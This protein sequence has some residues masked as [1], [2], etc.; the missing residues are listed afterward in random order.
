MTSTSLAPQPAGLRQTS[1]SRFSAE[2]R[3]DTSFVANPRP[4]LSWVVATDGTDWQQTRAELRLTRAGAVESAVHE[5]PESVLVEWPFAAIDAGEQ[6]AVEVRVSGNDGGTTAW[7]EP[8]TLVGGYLD[9]PWQ[10][11]GDR[12]ALP[13]PEWRFRSDS[14]ANCGTNSRWARTWPKPPCSPLRTVSTRP[15]ST[16]RKWMTRF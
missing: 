12:A 3:T 11:E 16:A 1:V 15:K 6:V 4:R 2:Y 13:L 7:S 9:G 8:L 5:G 10:A 14:P